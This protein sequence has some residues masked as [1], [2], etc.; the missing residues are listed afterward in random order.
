MKN[1]VNLCKYIYPVTMYQT[2]S[3]RHCQIVSN[4]FA[5]RTFNNP[6][7]KKQAFTFKIQ[8]S[9]SFFSKRQK[10]ALERVL[11][12]NDA[13][14]AAVL[15]H[16]RQKNRPVHFFGF[17][18]MLCKK[19]Q[20]FYCLIESKVFVIIMQYLQLGMNYNMYA[21]VLFYSV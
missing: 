11:N 17:C 9:L 12:F 13:V 4:F 8:L 14:A 10:N 2:C 6:Q 1:I 3:S 7:S 21:Y 5:L 18:S 20:T 16:Y 15:L 19:E